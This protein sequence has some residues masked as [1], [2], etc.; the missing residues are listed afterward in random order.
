MFGLAREQSI[1]PLCFEHLVE[2]TPPQLVVADPQHV[3]YACPVP[4]CPFC[5]QIAK[6]YFVD[7]KKSV[8]Q[9]VDSDLPRVTCPTDSLLMYLCETEP[10]Y[11][12]YRLW[13]CPRCKASHVDGD[14]PVRSSHAEGSNSSGKGLLN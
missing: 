1:Q 11:P 8:H 9:A 14:V 10:A 5:Y 4:D 3:I 12:K 13:R 2:M 7:A 6:G